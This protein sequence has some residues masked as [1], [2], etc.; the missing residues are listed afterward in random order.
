MDSGIRR[1]FGTEANRRHLRDLPI[2]RV[3]HSLP[4]NFGELLQELDQ[5]EQKRAGRKD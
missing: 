4:S 1:Q 5:A 3:D 2:F